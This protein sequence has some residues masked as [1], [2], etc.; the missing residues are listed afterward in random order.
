[1][2]PSP[3][4]TVVTSRGGLFDFW[5]GAFFSSPR[6]VFERTTREATSKMTVTLKYLDR[7]IGATPFLSFRISEMTVKTMTGK[8]T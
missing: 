3:T 1:M 2:A 5:A 6:H 8:Y 4:T 7:F